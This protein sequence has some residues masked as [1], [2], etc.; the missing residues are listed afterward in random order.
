MHGTHSCKAR[1]SGGLAS[2]WWWWWW[3][4]QTDREDT[5]V[6]GT[7]LYLSSQ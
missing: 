1:L 2:L 5:N 6:H 7:D 3:D 4:R